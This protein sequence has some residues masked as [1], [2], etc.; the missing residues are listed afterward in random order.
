MWLLNLSLRRP[1]TIFVGMVGLALL[2]YFA[3]LRLPID[4]FPNL[5]LPVIIVA[6]PY[7]GMDPAQMEGS[8]VYYYEYHFLYI[9][10]IDHVESK[11]IQNVGLVK[12]YFQPGTDM[13]QALAQ[14]VSYVD[15]ARAFMPPGT[16]A[17]FVVRFDAGTVP[18]GQLIFSS[19]NRSVGEIQDL[20][21]N[22]VR[23]T[24]AT[25]PG[26]SAPPPF[27]A[28]QRTVVIRVDPDRLR[29]LG[30]SAED[31]TRAVASGNAILPGGNVRIGEINHVAQLNSPVPRIQEME[32]IPIRVG[33]GPA[34]YVRDIAAVNDS[35]DILSGY[36]L[37]NGRRTV[38]IPVTKR[39][40]ASTLA[41]VQRVKR[42][43]PRM[44]SLIP[45]DI[46]IEFA[47]DQSVYV[48]NALRGLALEGALGALLTGLMVWLFLRDLRSAAIVLI[49]IPF[50]LA[51]AV[52]GLWLTGQTINIMTLGGLAL[53]I[54]ILVDESTVVIENLHTH[55]VAGE[56]VPQAILNA[57]RET[58]VPRL[59][60]MLSI[61]AVFLPS[62]FMTGVARS[63][64]IPL[65]LAVGFAMAA[66][67]GLSNTVVPVLAAGLL[68]HHPAGGPHRLL[69]RVHAGHDRV[70]RKA[71]SW[72]WAV[73]TVYVL[74]SVGGTA[75]VVRFLGTDMFPGTDAAQFQLRLRAP[76]GTRVERTEEIALKALD[77][78]RTEAGPDNVDISLAFVGTPASNYPI[79]S[80]YLWSSGPHEALLTVALRPKAG[81]HLDDL[82]ERLR[83][84]LPAALP[85]VTVSFEAGDIVSQIMNFGAPTPIEVAIG[86][87]NLTV[88]RAFAEKVAGEMRTIGTLRDLQFGQP[89]EY[90]SAN[91]EVN[92]ERAGQLGVTV[93]QV[94]RALA[95][96]TS[97]SRYLTPSYWRDPTSGIAYQVQV[98]IPQARIASLDAVG[99]MPVAASEAGRTLVEDVAQLSLGSMVGEYDRYN[100][101]RMVTIT[102]NTAGSD[103]GTA[104]RL[105]ADAVRRAGDPPRGVTVNVRGQVAPMNET[106]NGLRVGLLVAI[107]AIF[108]LMTANFQSVRLG[109]VVLSTIPAVMFGVGLALLLTRTTLNVQSFMGAIM[110][111]GVSVANAIL[112]VTFAEK[113]RTDGEESD[114]AAMTGARTRMRPIL[115]TSLAMIAGM[116]PMALAL[117]EGGEQTAPLGRAVIGGLIAST[118]A[119]LVVLPLVFGAVQQ[120]AAR[121]SASWHP[122]DAAPA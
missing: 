106:L 68:R 23:P 35:S 7:G 72:R 39:A 99:S 45:E 69:D 114:A 1:M 6:Q 82:R 28:S 104:A 93:E 88:D 42:E 111:I 63:L 105:V 19:D 55:L 66:S 89:L 91:I 57:G 90:P 97:S 59:L 76:T 87:P 71:F 36:A 8:L 77:V 17:P 122:D 79:N 44:R 58:M 54:G 95:A 3:F 26:V 102:A 50:A 46:K 115:M 107:V 18:V 94:G 11:S 34:I 4:I 51:G 5:N 80:I 121:G 109:L 43:L 67:Y 81:V 96:A 116:V 53:A 119:V 22:R 32:N 73:I 108:L 61:L 52:V 113:R 13:S 98:E 92:R 86:G 25:L 65:S 20:A 101:Q 120:R 110:A 70:V 16:V 31:V 47:F 60:A 85:T 75:L 30:L 12:L 27:G 24:F 37:V 103:L 15:R 29:A 49:T 64:F 40:D 33:S 118:I 56:S 78:I 38:Y 112:L 21:L 48:T 10:G 83:H 14:T 84:Q 2:G 100:Q 41:V 74:V 62:F 117:G 9:T